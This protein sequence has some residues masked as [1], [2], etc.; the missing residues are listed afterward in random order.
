MADGVFDVGGPLGPLAPGLSASVNPLALAGMGIYQGN[1]MGAMLG[2]A[3]LQQSAQAQQANLELAQRRM[4]LEAS[5]RVRALERE[6]KTED[7]ALALVN[8]MLGLLGPGV[9]KEYGDNLRTVAQNAPGLFMQFASPFVSAAAKPTE[10]FRPPTEEERRIYSLPAGEPYR[11]STLTGKPE[12]IGAPS[13]VFNIGERTAAAKSIA[14]RRDLVQQYGAGS[15]QVKAFDLSQ[16]TAGQQTSMGQIEPARQMLANIEDLVGTEAGQG[17][18]DL[19]GTTLGL[20]ARAAASPT[21][22]RLPGMNLTDEEAQLATYTTQLSNT[23]LALM[24]GAQVGPQEQA[25]FERQLPVMGQ[26]ENV[27]RSNLA[28]TKRNLEYLTDLYKAQAPS[29]FDGETPAPQGNLTQTEEARRQQ[30]LRKAQEP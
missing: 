11:I 16:L 22:S 1:P 28:A 26:D 13:M 7:A 23:M 30:L 9:A 20:R 6:R 18:I 3:Q 19:S 24:R 27:F 5:D 4:A 2:A 12:R 17:V 25:I 15:D 21:Y 8:P 29:L 10:R 14:D